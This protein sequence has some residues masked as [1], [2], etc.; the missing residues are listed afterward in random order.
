LKIFQ[1]SAGFDAFFPPDD[2]LPDHQKLLERFP[3]LDCF[4]ERHSLF[5]GK[6]KHPSAIPSVSSS[7]S[8]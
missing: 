5:G 1:D 6:S 7:P 3:N 8:L 4:G 2:R